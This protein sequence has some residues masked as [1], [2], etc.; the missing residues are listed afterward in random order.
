[1]DMTMDMT[2]DE[3]MTSY[4][5]LRRQ[6]LS[7][8]WA[9]GGAERRIYRETSAEPLET[10]GGLD[11]N[12]L[13]ELHAYRV[14]LA[15]QIEGSDTT[16]DYNLRPGSIQFRGGVGINLDSTEIPNGGQAGQGNSNQNPVDSGQPTAAPGALTT[17]SEEDH[18]LIQQVIL[19]KD[20]PYF[21]RPSEIDPLNNEQGYAGGGG[22][23][24]SGEG[25]TCFPVD[26]GV[27]GPVLDENDEIGLAGAF[28][29]ELET[30]NSL[31]IEAFVGMD[32]FWRMHEVSNVRRDYDLPV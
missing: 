28:V 17:F 3:S 15:V 7:F 23:H 30:Q 29:N 9:G 27:R 32:L 21:Q 25:L 24:K 31:S 11:H 14:T 18:G 19:Q 22:A 20:L 5:D 13:A 26:L 1:M 2:R 8:D 10:T 4:A 16:D 12:E 6:S